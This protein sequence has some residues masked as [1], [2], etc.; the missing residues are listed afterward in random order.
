MC[1]QSSIYCDRKTRGNAEGEQKREVANY[2]A[3]QR[4][5]PVV[6]GKYISSDV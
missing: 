2:R 5:T 6:L 4:R 3:G 1:A